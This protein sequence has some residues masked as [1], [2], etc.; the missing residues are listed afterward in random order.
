MAPVAPWQYVRPMGEDIVATEL[1]LPE[2]RPLGAVEVGACAAA[3]LTELEVRRRP[4]VPDSVERKV[5]VYFP[6]QLEVIG[7]VRLDE[8]SSPIRQRRRETP[9]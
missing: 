8:V 6:E 5:A 9:E 7:H 2:G 1:V 3:G 4:C